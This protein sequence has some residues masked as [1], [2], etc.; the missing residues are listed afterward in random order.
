M[1]NNDVTELFGHPVIHRKDGV[2]DGDAVPLRG[3]DELVRLADGHPG[4]VGALAHEERLRDP[5][6][7]GQRRPW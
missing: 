4:V 5:V 2:G 1:V 7:E 6:G 3:G